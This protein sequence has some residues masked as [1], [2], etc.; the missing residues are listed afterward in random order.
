M[1]TKLNLYKGNTKIKS[2]D[3][4]IEGRTTIQITELIPNTEYAKGDYALTYSND[5]GES[6]R[7]DV[8]AFKTLPIGVQTITLDVDTLEL[9]EGDTH[10]LVATV[11]PDNA[12]DKTVKFTTDS[13]A[14]ATVDSNGIITAIKEG[15]ANIKATST[16]GNKTDIV[17]VTVKAKEIEP[18]QNIVVE[19]SDV[20]TMVTAE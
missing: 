17:I 15:T 16:S 13:E 10:Q 11:K 3:K 18:P 6:N 8:P 20:N 2:V 12:T 1:A 9:T 19:P 4:A 7:V 14:T 5:S